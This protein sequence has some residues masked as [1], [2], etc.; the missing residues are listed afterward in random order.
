MKRA[1]VKWKLQRA[2]S[3]ERHLPALS[4]PLGQIARSIDERLAE[5]DARNLAAKGRGQKAS[6]PAD[7]GAHVQNRHIGGDPCQLGKI[8]GSGE[9]AGVKLVEAS[10]LLRHEP[11]FLR[12]EGR[13]RGLQPL[14]QVGRAIVIAHAIKGIGHREFPLLL[15]GRPDV[16][17]LSVND[18]WR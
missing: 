13:E 18:Y 16:G 2:G 3:L 14:G 6:R 4:R 7:P 5:V 1:V 8:S 17:F 15:I 11:L 12:P 10:Q 9:P